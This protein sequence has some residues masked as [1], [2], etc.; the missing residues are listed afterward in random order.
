M[1]LIPLQRK[2]RRRLVVSVL[3]VGLL[4]ASWGRLAAD[5]PLAFGDP[6][7]GLTTE[8]HQAFEIG[9]ED[10]LEVETVENG[11]GPVFNERSCAACH[12]VPATPTSMRWGSRA[13]TSRWKIAPSAIVVSCAVTR[14]LTSKMMAPGC[15][16]LPISCG[17]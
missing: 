15:R 9:L 3:S 8:E 12:S 17:S 1:P 6:L 10:F 13:P 11:L 4:G 16:P 14:C 5:D 7:P 2:P